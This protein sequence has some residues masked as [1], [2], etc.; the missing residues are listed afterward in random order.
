M[1]KKD[2]K[3]EFSKQVFNIERLKKPLCSLLLTCALAWEEWGPLAELGFGGRFHTVSGRHSSQVTMALVSVSGI[4][5]S[6]SITTEQA[7]QECE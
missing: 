5:S 7:M 6:I 4:F 2:S 1:L 3:T